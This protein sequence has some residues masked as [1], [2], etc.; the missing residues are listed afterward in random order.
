MI[1]GRHHPLTVAS[2][3]GLGG[4]FGRVLQIPQTLTTCL[5]RLGPKMAEKWQ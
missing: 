1:G 4:G 3:F 5:S 2:D